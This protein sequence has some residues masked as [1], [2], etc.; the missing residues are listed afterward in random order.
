MEPFYV[1]LLPERYEA[2]PLS[3][4]VWT[5]VNR[6]FEGNQ[7]GWLIVE[8]FFWRHVLEGEHFVLSAQVADPCWFRLFCH[9]FSST[10]YPY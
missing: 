6:F 9:S 4:I 8:G 2:R 7:E 3:G 10:L 5:E 1:E